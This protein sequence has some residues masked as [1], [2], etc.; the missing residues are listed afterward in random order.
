MVS[1]ILVGQSGGSNTK[2][3]F[4]DPEV[5]GSNPVVTGTRALFHKTFYGRNLRISVLS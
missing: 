5:E 2:E 3:E 1:V 4:I